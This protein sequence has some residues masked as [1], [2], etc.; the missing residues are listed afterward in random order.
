M[1]V[2]FGRRFCVYEGDLLLTTTLGYDFPLSDYIL[3]SDEKP[4][5]LTIRLKNDYPMAAEGY[6][7][8]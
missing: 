6:M 1:R 2:V 7:S 5:A 4:K 8:L 3:V